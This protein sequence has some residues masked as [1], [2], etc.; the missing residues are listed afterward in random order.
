MHTNSSAYSDSER[1][2]GW[3]DRYEDEYISGGEDEEDDEEGGGDGYDH[4]DDEA[5]HDSLD[6]WALAQIV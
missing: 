5:S 3:Y 2:D 6:E 1:P 4:S